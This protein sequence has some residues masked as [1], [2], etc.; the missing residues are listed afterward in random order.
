MDTDSPAARQQV[1]RALR[2]ERRT[3]KKLRA[4]HADLDDTFSTAEAEGGLA[5][6]GDVE[7]LGRVLEAGSTTEKRVRRL[8]ALRAHRRYLAS[9]RAPSRPMHLHTAR[10]VCAGGRRRPGVRRQNRAHAPPDDP[11][12]DPDP[13]PPAGQQVGPLRRSARPQI[14]RL[15]PRGVVA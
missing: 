6:M 11:G 2:H 12:G 14:D 9:A 4:K 5:C 3:L 8:E 1:G 13:E 10:R 15:A 7:A